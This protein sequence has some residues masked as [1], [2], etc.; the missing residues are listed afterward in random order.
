MFVSIL[1]WFCLYFGKLGFTREREI[2]LEEVVVDKDLDQFL[3]Y[4]DAIPR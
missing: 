2:V 1:F 3:E 4:R